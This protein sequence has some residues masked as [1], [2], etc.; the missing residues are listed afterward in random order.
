MRRCLWRGLATD[1]KLAARQ[2]QRYVCKLRDVRPELDGKYLQIAGR[3]KP[4]PEMGRILDALRDALLDG[5]V[6]HARRAGG[7]CERERLGAGAY[8]AERV[9]AQQVTEGGRSYAIDPTSYDSRRT[10]SGRQT[11]N[12]A[13]SAG[14]LVAASAA[15]RSA[16]TASAG[17]GAGLVNIQPTALIERGPRARAASRF[18]TRRLRLLVGSGGRRGVCVVPGRNCREIGNIQ[19]EVKNDD[20]KSKSRGTQRSH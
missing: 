12:R 4:G 2:I 13:R 15:R 18:E 7:V 6:K 11:G 5:E 14:D 9:N 10:D 3:C 20:P 17:W 16:R 19:E 1:S 8:V